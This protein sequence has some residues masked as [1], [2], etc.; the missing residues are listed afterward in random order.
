M[1][2]NA[3]DYALVISTSATAITA[4]SGVVLPL[5]INRSDKKVKR[6]E[7]RYAKAADA[8][9][10][11]T[12][13]IEQVVR[14]RE[15][16]AMRMAYLEED[17]SVPDPEERREEQSV[18]R[19]FEMNFRM[20]QMMAEEIGVEFNEFKR[21]AIIAR[22]SVEKYRV[23]EGSLKKI[24]DDPD[25]QEKKRQ[26]IDNFVIQGARMLKGFREKLELD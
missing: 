26:A 24:S 4:L 6:R 17:I 21:Y 23:V 10:F 9:Y 7:E 1:N 15:H 8:V 22:T 13:N 14:H 20:V 19:A 16:E 18:V 12:E 3:S 5:W 2:W 11:C 25:T